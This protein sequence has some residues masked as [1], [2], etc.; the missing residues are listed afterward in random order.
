MNGP[1]DTGA[2]KPAE[3]RPTR[4][5]RKFSAT[6]RLTR[7]QSRRQNDVLQS[8]WRH[9]GVTGPMI[10]FLNERNEQLEGRQPLHIAVES[11]DGLRR[12]EH[13]LGEMTYKA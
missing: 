7:D 8:A 4:Q 3:V 5:F 10:A 11:D 9:F 1:S 6:A 2:A 12:V 13:L